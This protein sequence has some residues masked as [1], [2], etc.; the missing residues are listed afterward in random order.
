MKKHFPWLWFDA[1]NTLFDYDRA[2]GLALKNTFGS[3]DLRFEDDYLDT[4]QRINRGLWQALEKQEI[5][6]DV[7][8]VRRFEQLLEAVQLSGS[9]DQMS[10]AYIEQLGMCAELMDG[11]YQ[12]L[13]TLQ[14]KCKFA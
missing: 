3:L 13:D 12:V 1:D 9:A 7:L 14:G 4:Y 8:R 5:T 11:V 2:E 10:S 6:S